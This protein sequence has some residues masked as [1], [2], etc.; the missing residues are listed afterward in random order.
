[1][2]RIELQ[3][4]SDRKWQRWLAD[5]ERATTQL[6]EQVA[7]GDAATVTKL[8]KRK[9][10]KESYFFCKGPP[11]YGKCAYC[12]AP[13]TDYQHGDVEHFRPKLAV[14]DEDDQPV[15]LRDDAGN[16]IRDAEGRPVPHPGYYWLAY[17]WTNLLPSCVRC[18]QP[19]RIGGKKIGKHSRFPVYGRHAQSPDE[20]AHEQPLLIHPGE[21]DPAEHLSIDP[22]TGLAVSLTERGRTCVD[23]LG[24]NLRDQLVADRRKAGDQVWHLLNRVLRP[25]GDAQA[26]QELRDIRNGKQPFTMA[27]I[28]VLDEARQLMAPV[29]S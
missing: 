26:A 13:I 27:Q 12:E 17:E 5:C 4:P 19:S 2:R 9:S 14:T 22:A 8:Y 15:F 21:D 7:G 24:L 10:I 18:D 20:V 1:V 3:P 28:A 6:C 16:V 25:G 23:L 11:F 29:L